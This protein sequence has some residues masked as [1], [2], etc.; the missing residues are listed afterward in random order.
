M[1][2]LQDD[3]YKSL[4]PYFE[5]FIKCIQDANKE[6][7]DAIVPESRGK[8][9]KRTIS[10]LMNDI[11]SHNIRKTFT[12]VSGFEVIER[13]SQTQIRFSSE[14]LIKTKQSK[15]NKIHFIPTQLALDFLEQVEQLK[16][17]DMPSAITNLILTYEWDITR[18]NIIKISFLCPV[19]KRDYHYEIPVAIVTVPEFAVD[20]RTIE[21][22]ELKQKRVQPKIKKNRKTN[23]QNGDSNNNGKQRKANKS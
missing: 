8:A 1:V 15:N 2:A 18:T 3:V 17:H 5:Q 14:L 19:N 11:V 16:L 12:G 21:H 20:S 9:K 23:K 13:Y 22:N 7:R 4:S 6:Q 10:T